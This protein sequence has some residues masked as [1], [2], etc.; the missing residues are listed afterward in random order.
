[1]MAIGAD[2]PPEPT[3]TGSTELGPLF[4]AAFVAKLERLVVVA[5]R[6]RQASRVGDKKAPRR[7]S[8]LEFS[9]HRAYAPGDDLR[10]LD[11]NL[12]GR[13]GR[14][15]VRLYEQEEEQALFVLIDT[16][17]SMALGGPRKA[18]LALQVAAA[19]AYIGLCHRDA[20][21]LHPFAETLGDPLTSP[22]DR[23]PFAALLARLGALGFRGSADLPATL[24][25][26]RALPSRPGVCIVVSDLLEVG[27]VPPAVDHLLRR[28]LEVALLRITSPQ[29][30]EGTGLGPGPTRL[31]DSETGTE[32]D[33]EL[34]PALLR[35]YAERFSR[36][37]AALL[38]H[39][40]R[41]RVP[42]VS[43]D[44]AVPFDEVV[45]RLLR[46]EGLLL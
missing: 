9:D 31:C 25:A 35:R 12:F 1:M 11:W 29:D 17:A 39:A 20:V 3:S 23:G 7:G 27:P 42:F 37:E 36:Q 22:P 46:A 15:M 19:L 14:T 10:R 33:L 28:K 44:A 38:G 16:S 41:R 2:S 45:L 4:D 24:G 21:F 26:L 18:D 30:R 6:L 13:L 34:T 8:G 32:V 40:R 5:K 43:V